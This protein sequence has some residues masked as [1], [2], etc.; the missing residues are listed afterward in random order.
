[1]TLSVSSTK[2]NKDKLRIERIVITPLSGPV[3]TE[4]TEL[5]LAS[6]RCSEHHLEMMIG[7]WPDAPAEA[8]DPLSF[9]LVVFCS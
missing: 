4:Y 6:R 7:S 3:Y 1:M 5:Q 9:A 2:S 8:S